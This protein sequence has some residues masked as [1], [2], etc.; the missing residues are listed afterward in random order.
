MNELRLVGERVVLR[1][2][3]EADL[4]PLLRILLEPEIAKWWPD[5]NA[6]RLRADTL[7]DAS[8]TTL[9]IELASGELVGL[10]MFAEELDPYYK[11]ASM[12]VTLSSVCIGQGLGPDALRTLATH[13]FSARG[14][15]RLTIDPA[16][17]NSRAIA[18]YRKIGFRPVGIMRCYELGPGGVWRDGLLM[19]LLKGEL[20]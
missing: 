4:E 6:E 17:I 9:V 20:T 16:A 14:H 8:S 11:S 5:Y 7:D 10:I 3:T 13:L 1:P 15:H 18:A 2:L 12:D 19:D